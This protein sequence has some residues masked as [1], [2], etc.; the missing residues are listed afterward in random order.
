MLIAINE[1]AP[2]GA[3]LEALAAIS[4]LEPPAITRGGVQ[5]CGQSSANVVL[6]VV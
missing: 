6:F 4:E 1:K 2:D 3:R 5:R